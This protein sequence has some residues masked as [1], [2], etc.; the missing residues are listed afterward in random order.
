MS[1]NP[2][3]LGPALVNTRPIKLGEAWV[4]RESV[5]TR[6]RRMHRGTIDA[7]LISLATVLRQQGWG[8]E[9][10]ELQ[11]FALSKSSLEL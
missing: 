8:G 11:F 6:N 4:R 2:H 3:A 1:L 5:V 10:G 7:R 9:L